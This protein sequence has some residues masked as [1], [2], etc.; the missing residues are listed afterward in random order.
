MAFMINL[1]IAIPKGC[2]ELQ[3]SRLIDAA[4]PDE[5]PT[6]QER[7]SYISIVSEIRERMRGMAESTDDI[8]ANPPSKWASR[9][10]LSESSASPLVAPLLAFWRYLNRLIDD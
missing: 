5:T 6:Q 2:T 7:E 10:S 4:N 9:R 8:I 3:A 1:G